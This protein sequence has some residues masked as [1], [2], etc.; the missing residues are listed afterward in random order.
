MGQ[1]V[2]PVGFR[3]GYIRGW[4][5]NWY[6]GKN[7][8]EKLVEDDKIRKYINARIPKGSVS[9]VVIERTLKR[10]T[11]TIHT[12]R[13]GIVI[14]KAGSEVDKLREELKKLTKKDVQINI[15]E[16]K[17][18]EIDAKLVGETIAQQLR[19]RISFR[20]AMKQA[21]QS[22]MRVG[23]QG[24]K[25]KLSGR[26]GGA[27]MA[28]SEMYKEG[29][30]PLHTLRADIDYAISES[31]TVYGLIGI[32]VWI[33]KGEVFG[34]RDLTS[35]A[36]LA[37]ESA[38]SKKSSMGGPGGSNQGKGRRDDDGDKNGRRK[39]TNNSGGGGR[40]NGQKRN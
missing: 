11:L 29:R 32:K 15:F 26:L 4:E 25:I 34:K 14:G 36:A 13:P 10:I 9:R 27:E 31:L 5:S 2:N 24:I 37:T 39:K 12:A 18:P 30:I 16:I 3:L 38:D 6:G 7:F 19:A 21:I 40:S 8:A 1:T 22:A 28:R 23:A 17:R 33:F 35:V 20:R